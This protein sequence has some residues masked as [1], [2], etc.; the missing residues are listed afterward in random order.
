M[1]CFCAAINLKNINLHDMSKSHRHF[2]TVPKKMVSFWFYNLLEPAAYFFWSKR[3]SHFRIY[4]MPDAVLII[5]MSP[6]HHTIYDHLW[7]V[8]PSWHVGNTLV[9]TFTATDNLES[10]VDIMWFNNRL[11]PSGAKLQSK[12]MISGR[13]AA[14]NTRPRALRSGLKETVPN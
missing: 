9:L 1:F 10:L 2:V 5:I 6:T 4:L 13:T 11:R 3:M 7:R 8:D 14:Q 12:V